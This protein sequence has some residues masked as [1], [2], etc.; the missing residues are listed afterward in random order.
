MTQQTTQQEQ[1]E[2]EIKSKD[3]DAENGNDLDNGGTD[4]ESGSGDSSENLTATQLANALQ[5][6]IEKG[7]VEL[8]SDG[9]QVVVNFPRMKIPKKIYPHYCKKHLQHLMKPVLQLVSQKEFYLVV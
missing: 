7:Q 4:A 9:E 1:R 2:V 8:Q 5:D 3:K 6:A